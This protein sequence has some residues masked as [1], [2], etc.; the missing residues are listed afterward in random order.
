MD[1]ICEILKNSKNIAVVGISNKPGRDSGKIAHFL[2][3]VGYNV[4]GVN[5]ELKVFDGIPV[6]KSLSDIPETIDIVD[7]FRRPEYVVDIV[8]EAIEI[9][10]KVVWMQLGV[11][12]YEAEKLAQE[13]GLKVIMN[14]CIAIEYRRCFV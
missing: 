1:S 3:E 11:I 6:Y 8:K 12:N 5:P 14:K 13:A 9:K 7:I 2:H 4:F 10:A